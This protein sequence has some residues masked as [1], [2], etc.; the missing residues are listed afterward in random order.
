MKRTRKHAILALLLML[1]VA[2][3]A[4][5]TATPAAV[6]A[7]SSAPAASESAS[8]SASASASAEAPETGSAVNLTIM[9]WGPDAR[10]EATLK[11]LDAYTAMNPQVTFTPEY[12]AWDGYWTKLPTLVASG[13]MTDVLQMDG[14]YIKDYVSR[15]TLADLSDMPLGETV[16]QKVL[17]N[18]AIDGK[19]YGV[20]LSHNAQGMAFNKVALEEAGITLP[21]K[22]WTWDDFWA[23]AYEAREKL[24][25]DKWG[26]SYSGGV[27]DDFQYYQVSM[28]KG[29][30]FS[31][32]GLSYNIDKD[33]FLEYY[34]KFQQARKDNVV[35]PAEVQL[36]FKEND[37]QADPMASGKVMTRGATVGSVNA[38]ESLLP[39]AVAVVNMPQGPNGGGWAQSTIFFSSAATSSKQ[40]EAK[41]FMAWFISDIEAGKIL[42][43]TR[44]IPISE[45]VYKVLEPDMNAG[46]ILGKELLSVS[47]D[48]A[49]PFYPAAPGWQDYTAGFKAEIENLMFDGETVEEAYENIIALAE[50]V[51]S[52]VSGSK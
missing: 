25:A 7:S 18:I 43:T 44:G 8:E 28:G 17:D 1:L 22:D 27:W 10:H 26:I 16:P 15:D 31:E 48:G 46:S 39:G 30:I 37:A 9:W 41:A 35:P 49:Q 19:I 21:A 14:A 3:S 42:G 6:G 50:Q 11:A 23:F 47:L 12:I 29:S 20:P 2:V 52:K 24:P 4:C 40:A 32:D 38:L 13:S 36:A 33:L 51:K 5:G 34:N 45:E